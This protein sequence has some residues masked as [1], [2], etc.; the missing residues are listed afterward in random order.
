MCK[1]IHREKER[2]AQRSAASFSAETESAE[3]AVAA[4]E[5]ALSAVAILQTRYNYLISGD[6]FFF[7]S[8]LQFDI[9]LLIIPVKFPSY[10]H[11]SYFTLYLSYKCFLSYHTFFFYVCTIDVLKTLYLNK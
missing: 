8:L 4:I 11:F 1:I 7:K 10:F 5:S 3:L 6:I 9:G 2:E